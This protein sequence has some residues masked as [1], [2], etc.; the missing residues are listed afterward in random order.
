MPGIPGRWLLL[1]NEWAPGAVDSGCELYMPASETAMGLTQMRDHIW[2]LDSCS[3]VSPI[4]GAAPA[5]V[6]S[7]QPATPHAAQ[8]LQL[9]KT[10]RR[11]A[12]RSRAPAP[13]L[14]ALLQSQQAALGPL[15][16]MIQQA[17]Q[18]RSPTP[19]GGPPVP[20]GR[21]Q[22]QQDV[23]G[24][25]QPVLLLVDPVLEGLPLEGLQASTSL[26]A[27][28]KAAQLARPHCNNSACILL[29]S[30]PRCSR[31]PHSSL[32]GPA[33]AGPCILVWKA[34][35]QQGPALLPAMLQLLCPTSLHHL[36]LAVWVPA[37]VAAGSSGQGL[38]PARAAQQA[39]VTRRPAGEVP[40][41]Q[42]EAMSSLTPRQ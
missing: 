1:L 18:P 20:K 38:L 40:P 8:T 29:I 5:A 22:A 31:T 25:L 28:G 42:R 4:C 37:G 34:L 17:L 26:P 13:A 9:P 36:S 27:P 2:D 11:P 30:W 35:L 21:I 16:P 32:H 10:G 19:P 14:Q 39:A 6:C 23:G 41:Q 24:G 33:A 3:G 15:L 12:T 7:R